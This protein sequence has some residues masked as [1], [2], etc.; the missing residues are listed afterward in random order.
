MRGAHTHHVRLSEGQVTALPNG[1][2][3]SGAAALTSNGSLAG[4]S[5]SRVEIDINGETAVPFANVAMTFG[6]AA[7]SHFGTQPLRGV[8][9]Y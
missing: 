5:G 2:R 8:V 3:I 7:A 1:Y 4:F 6:G 9:T